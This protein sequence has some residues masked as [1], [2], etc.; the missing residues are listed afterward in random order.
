AG[1]V[2]R[3][4][5][6]IR[7]LTRERLDDAD[8]TSL[9]VIVTYQTRL[10]L[11]T[12]PATKSIRELPAARG[13]ALR[14]GRAQAAKFWNAIRPPRAPDNRAA[15]M[16]QGGVRKV[17][18]DRRMTASLDRSVPQI[19]APAAWQAGYDGSGV[20]VAVL[21]TGADAGHPDLAGRIAGSSDF[22]DNGS[23]ADGN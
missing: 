19:G 8:A 23:T 15:A 22:T 14:G 7:E 20:T 11:N 21:D 13:R 9:P 16:L 6:N 2:D 17:W 3:E 4:L 5:F 18:P 12:L 10:P 1:A